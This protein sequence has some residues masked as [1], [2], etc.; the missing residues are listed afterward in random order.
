MKTGNNFS[1]LL[2]NFTENY[3]K[4]AKMLLNAEVND[5][6]IPK[7]EEA[8]SKYISLID[9]FARS[10]SSDISKNAISER[11]FKF[12]NT[13]NNRDNHICELIL[14]KTD[15]KF[16]KLKLTHYTGSFDYA[17]FQ[18]IWKFKKN[19]E[20][21]AKKVFSTISL[22]INSIKDKHNSERNPASTLVPMIREAVKPIAPTYQFK[23]Q[24]LSLDESDLQRGE[25][26]WQQ[27][28]YGNKYPELQ[29][30]SKQE[31]FS[32]NEKHET[33]KR[34]MYVDRNTKVTKEI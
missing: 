27:A 33:F 3:A 24:I 11:I 6:H 28:I 8:T 14:R 12:I 31:K 10:R 32:G 34:T 7:I 26:N 9:K 15:E 20:D 29:E 18:H 23:K 2:N 17:G 5:E 16:L 21:F 25:N 30:E 4:I 13:E 1:E 22:A 19:E